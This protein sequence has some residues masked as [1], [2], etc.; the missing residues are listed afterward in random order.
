MGIAGGGTYSNLKTTMQ[1]LC[2]DRI[3]NKLNGKANP[4]FVNHLQALESK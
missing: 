4:V 2:Q 3:P 1:E